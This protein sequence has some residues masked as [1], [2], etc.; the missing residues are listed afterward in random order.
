[1]S[2]IISNSLFGFSGACLTSSLRFFALECLCYRVSSDWLVETLKNKLFSEQS[3]K[4]PSVFVMPS[5]FRLISAT[6]VFGRLLK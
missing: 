4:L 6:L 3:L 5:S 1:M 2:F